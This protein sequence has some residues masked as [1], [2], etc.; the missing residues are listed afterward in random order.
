MADYYRGFAEY[1]DAQ[2]ESVG[3]RDDIEFYVR[4]A[5]ASK[6]P[7][8]EMGCGT[9][10]VTVP[11][12]KA[13]AAVTGLDLCPDMLE[14]ARRQV[15]SLPGSIRERARF[16]QA[17]M[18][19]FSIDGKFD[20]IVTPFR[21]FQHLT[22]PEEQLACLGRVRS[23]LAPGG[24]FV[25]DIFDPDLDILTDRGRVNE[26][27][28]EPPIT[29]PDG[30]ELT[31]RYRTPGIDTTAQVCHCEMIYLILHP[32]GRRD[33]FVQPFT[34]RWTYRYEAEHLLALSGFRVKEVFGG[35]RGEPV[36]AGE[37]VFLAE[38]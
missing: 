17:D 26:F 18:T 21:P 29:L 23:H 8:L 31:V 5:A 16:V 28:D 37:L 36:G 34:M 11:M 9:G 25:L 35:Y 12:L 3:G 30:S 13:G 10:R 19:D 1:Y 27:G 33:R 7:V 4:M 15:S 2:V 38:A 32:D 20:L 22:T 24:T 14:V 6:G